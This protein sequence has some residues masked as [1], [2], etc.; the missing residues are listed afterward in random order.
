MK[1]ILLAAAALTALSTPAM[2]G[3]LTVILDGVEAGPAPIYVSLQREG[4]FMQARGSYGTIV[5]DA[6]SGA[7]T[8]TLAGVEP[9]DYA[10]SVWHDTNG[11]HIFTMGERGPRDGWAMSFAGDMAALRGPPTFAQARFAVGDEA[12]A[13]TVRMHYPQA[14]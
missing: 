1:M 11:D 14:Q 8:V 4:E 9:G 10:L 12:Q 7:V 5:H 3:D 2:A 6:A 13:I